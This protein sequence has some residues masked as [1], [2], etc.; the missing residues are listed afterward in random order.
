MLKAKEYSLISPNR[1]ADRHR[2]P[3][4]QITSSY[5]PTRKVNPLSAGRPI[6]ILGELAGA[7]E[8]YDPSL[9]LVDRVDV[10][11]HYS[12]RK[13]EKAPGFDFDLSTTTGAVLNN[14]RSQWWC[15]PDETPPSTCASTSTLL[16]VRKA[17]SL[18]NSRCITDL[19]K[20]FK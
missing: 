3:S 1:G 6:H 7:N 11:V 16:S 2:A 4:R 14:C 9:W 20:V 12:W 19:L 13:M 8:A 5:S 18:E 15:H 17:Y 10:A